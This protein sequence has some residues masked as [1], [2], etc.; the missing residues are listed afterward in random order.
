MIVEKGFSNLFKWGF[1]LPKN[2]NFGDPIATDE[3]VFIVNFS[4]C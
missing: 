1:T 2:R 3:R 4:L